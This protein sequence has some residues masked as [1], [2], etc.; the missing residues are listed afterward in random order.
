MTLFRPISPIYTRPPEQPSSSQTSRLASRDSLSQPV[1]AI[2]ICQ[3][4]GPLGP[5][6][7]CPHS[8]LSATPSRPPTTSPYTFPSHHTL[9]SPPRHRYTRP[10]F[11]LL[12]EP[13][14]CLLS[15]NFCFAGLKINPP[16]LPIASDFYKTPVSALAA[17]VLVALRR[18]RADTPPQ[19]AN[20]TGT[21]TGTGTRHGR[22]HTA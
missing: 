19:P 20:Q 3:T 2:L 1:A 6:Q 9:S 18:S 12:L 4:R 8:P 11:P 17:I 7:T 13:L 5:A 21:Y 14:L 16:S 10:L 15:R 22:Q